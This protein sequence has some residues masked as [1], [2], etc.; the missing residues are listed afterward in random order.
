MGD[1]LKIH[2]LVHYDERIINNMMV[3]T[4]SNQSTSFPTQYLFQTPAFIFLI[5]SH[6]LPCRAFCIH[7][8]SSLDFKEIPQK[9][10][11]DFFSPSE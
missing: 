9:S 11:V 3:L 8:T 6:V 7:P 4:I 10:D 1:F 5:N 2:R